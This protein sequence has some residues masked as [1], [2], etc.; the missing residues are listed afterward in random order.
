[1]RALGYQLGRPP[2]HTCGLVTTEYVHNCSYF[3]IAFVG[4]RLLLGAVT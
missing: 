2:P 1:M 3:L 4:T